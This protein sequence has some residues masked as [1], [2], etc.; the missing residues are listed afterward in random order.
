MAPILSEA[1]DP[2]RSVE[3]DAVLVGAMARNQKS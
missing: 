3:L 1:A 2:C